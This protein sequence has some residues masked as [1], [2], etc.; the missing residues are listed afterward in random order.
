LSDDGFRRRAIGFHR[1]H[2]AI[3]VSPD[4]VSEVEREVLEEALSDASKLNVSVIGI[5]FATDE[6]AVVMGFPV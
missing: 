1:A 2:P 3:E 4:F 5:H 6:P